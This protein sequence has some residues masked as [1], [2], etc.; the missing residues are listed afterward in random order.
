M[1]D[2]CNSDV[3]EQNPLLRCLEVRVFPLGTVKK[4]LCPV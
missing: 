3:A 1:V 4:Y 2:K